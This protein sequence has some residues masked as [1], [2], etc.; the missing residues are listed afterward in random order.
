M[1]KSMTLLL[2]LSAQLWAGGFHL[3]TGRPA[4]NKDAQAMNAALTVTAMGCRNPE[5]AAVTATAIGIVNGEKRTIA[6]KLKPLPQP[7]AYAVTRQWPAGGRWVLQFVATDEDRVTS[8]LIV[9]NPD[10]I[11]FP[12]A[13]LAMRQPNAAEVEALLND[14]SALA[15]K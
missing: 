7:G 14:G 13:K 11:D 15:R 5:K 10:G 3:I 12:G 4:V 6:L 9:S 2:A 8:T 1:R